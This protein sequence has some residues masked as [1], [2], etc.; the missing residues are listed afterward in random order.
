MK[1]ALPK[2]QRRI[3]ELEKFDV[4]TIRKRWD[5]VMEALAKM[6]NGTLQEV[7]GH[8]TVE[9]NEYSVY[10]LDTLPLMIGGGPDPLPHVQDGYQEGIESAVLKL[11]TLKTLFEERIADAAPGIVP[12]PGFPTQDAEGSK[13]IFIVHGWDEGAKE[14]VARYISKLDLKPVILH[15]QANQGRTIIEKFEIHGGVEYAIV[16]FTPDD[17]GYPADE[18]AQA[19][20]RPRQNVILELG[21]FMAALG[22][23]R[24]CVLHKGSVEIPSDYAGV[25]YVEFDNGGAW[26][27]TVAR[28]MK[29]V[30]IDIDMNKVI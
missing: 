10:S 22:R 18:P 28:E 16:I 29:S 20:P 4:K 14:T 5:P 11:K 13:R 19:K 24:V 9:Y 12:N 3:T 15:E 21:F 8:G 23:D 26:R 30:G 2:L 27:F 6:V 1:A 7:L 17:I 25:L